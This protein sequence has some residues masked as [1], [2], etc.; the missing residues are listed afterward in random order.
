MKIALA[1]FAIFVLL[2]VVFS[3]ILTENVSMVTDMMSSWNVGE[4]ATRSNTVIYS[5]E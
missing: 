4:T 1:L 5:A 3:S 2:F